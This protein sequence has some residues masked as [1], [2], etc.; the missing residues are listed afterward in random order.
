MSYTRPEGVQLRP[1]AGA[2]DGL[3]DDPPTHAH[4]SGSSARLGIGASFSS[5]PLCQDPQLQAT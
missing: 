3:W 1:A 4:T 5:L 2:Q